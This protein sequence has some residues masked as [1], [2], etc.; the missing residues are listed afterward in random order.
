MVKKVFQAQKAKERYVLRSGSLK[1]CVA[2]RLLEFYVIRFAM[3]YLL[4]KA[5][6]VL[7]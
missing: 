5:K 3:R 7:Y 1:I 4:Q 6:P 2:L